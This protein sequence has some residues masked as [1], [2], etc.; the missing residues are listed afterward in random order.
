MIKIVSDTIF[1]AAIIPLPRPS[2]SAVLVV[3]L[4]G[5]GA[6]KIAL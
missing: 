3:L 1:E 4:L 2:D 5:G 6:L